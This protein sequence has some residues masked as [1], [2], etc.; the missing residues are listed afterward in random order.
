MTLFKSP[1]A[2]RLCRAGKIL[3]DD[4]GVAAVEFAMIL[5][6]MLTIM[7]GMAAVTE[8]TLVVH[9]VERVANSV[10]NIV[11]A[12]VTGG[13]NSGQGGLTDVDVTDAFKAAEFLLSPLPAANLHI[14]IY[15]I[16]LSCTGMTGSGSSGNASFLY[17]AKVVWKAAQNGLNNL[18]CG[19]ALAAG[20]DGPNALPGEYLTTPGGSS[21]AAWQGEKDRYIIVTHVRYDY[22]PPFGIGPFKWVSPQS[23]QIFRA[24]HSQNRSVFVPEHIQNKTT[25]SATTCPNMINP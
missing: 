15:E 13:T 24:G 5:P 2:T 18:Q 10:A 23:S 17:Q 21:E 12:K 20:Y 14:D 8:S 4:R 1:P 11:A 7:F 25:G 19:V 22:T 3:G 9:K 6:V 16:Q